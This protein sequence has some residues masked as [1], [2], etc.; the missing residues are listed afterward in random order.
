MGTF[1]DWVQDFEP[2]KTSRLSSNCQRHTDSYIIKTL[3]GIWSEDWIKA[4]WLVFW[5]TVSCYWLPPPSVW[6]QLDVSREVTGLLV[7]KQTTRNERA[8]T[9]WQ[10]SADTRLPVRSKF[11]LFPF[12]PNGA[13]SVFW[14]I[15]ILFLFNLCP[16]EAAMFANNILMIYS[17]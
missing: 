3:A 15:I 17:C 5:S 14:K 8:S 1:F 10:S 4:D 2:M 16:L 9:V 13:L 7:N 11:K 6:V 12:N